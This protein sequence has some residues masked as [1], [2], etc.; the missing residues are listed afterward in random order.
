MNGDFLALLPKPQVPQLGAHPPAVEPLQATTV[1]A[2]HCAAGVIIAGD[3][4]ATAGNI[5]FSDKTEKILELDAHSLMAIAGVPATAFEMAR[6]LQTSF[7]FYRRSQL[8]SMSLP[9][10]IRALSQLLRNNLAAT[11][12]GFGIVSPIFAGVETNDPEAT[13]QIYFYDP[14]GA[15]FEATAYAGSGSGSGHV[16]S[17][18]SFLERW[19]QPK[20][21]AMPLP[22]AVTLANRLLVTAAVFDT[23]TG[24]VHPEKE[25]FATIKLLSRDGIRSIESKEQ[26]E[27]WRE[28][29]Q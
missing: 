10:K 3:H 23:A 12:Q 18:L 26:A 15:Q 13:P 1:F 20:P 2:F 8:Q 25:Q 16:K 21:E 5:V 27:M 19:G 14:L 7:E 28:G 22:Q 4:R 17:V 29:G 11:I 24:G 6:T 9:A